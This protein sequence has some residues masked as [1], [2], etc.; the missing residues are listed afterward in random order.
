V[1]LN[2][3]SVKAVII[4][5]QYQRLGW[6]RPM[7]ASEI[8]K[9]MAALGAPADAMAATLLISTSEFR[10][11]MREGELPPYLALHLRILQQA[12]SGSLPTLPTP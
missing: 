5:A 9:L 3:K 11:R 7:P 6:D 4:E 2:N 12:K 8:E 1:S 10:R